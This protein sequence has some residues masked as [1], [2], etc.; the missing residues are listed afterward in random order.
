[1][2]DKITKTDQEWQEQLTLEQYRVCREQW[3]EPPFSGKY[4]D[5]KEAGTYHCICCGQALFASQDK[6]D[7]GS[8]WPS[9]TEPVSR[10]V[11]EERDDSSHAMQ[12]TEIICSKCDA[13]LGHVFPD[14]PEPSGLRYCINS[15]ALELKPEG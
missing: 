3:T 10:D 8:G 9:Y 6:F 15:I 11:V 13:H 5:C 14:G 4:V 1:M 12:R 2:T 7:S